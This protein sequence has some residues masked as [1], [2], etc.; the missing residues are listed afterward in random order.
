MTKKLEEIEE[1]ERALD[2]ERFCEG[3]E[4]ISDTVDYEE[5]WG[6]RVARETPRCP[7]DFWPD[8]EDCPRRDEWLDAAERLE[9][10]RRE[11][12]MLSGEEAEVC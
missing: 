7:A 3:C 1:L 10:L 8:A 5:Y 6:F 12:E 9:A 2:D 11:C 4:Y